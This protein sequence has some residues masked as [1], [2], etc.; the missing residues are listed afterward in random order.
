M[1]K[2]K[3]KKLMLERKRDKRKLEEPKK[4]VTKVLRLTTV[5]LIMMARR[6]SHIKLAMLTF[7]LPR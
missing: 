7:V 6:M 1:K 5:T 4:I 3:K 2:G